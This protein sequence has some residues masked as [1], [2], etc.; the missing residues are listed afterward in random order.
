GCHR[1]TMPIAMGDLTSRRGL[2]HVYTGEGKGKTTAA[3]GVALRAIGWG[4]RVCVIQ[5]IKGYSDIGEA[6][7][8]REFPERLTL[9]QLAVDLSR[10]I[11]EAK[12]A[13]RRAEAEAAM[14]Y[15]EAAVTSGEYDLIILDEINNAVHYGL[16]DVSRLLCLIKVKPDGLELILTGRSAHKEVIEAADYVTEMRTVKHPYEQGVQA[17]KGFDY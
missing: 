6:Q 3:L 15:A 10:S 7:F 11:D 5:F 2:V 13:Q 14:T 9:K 16:I 4:L 1:D 17:R 12:V 8:A